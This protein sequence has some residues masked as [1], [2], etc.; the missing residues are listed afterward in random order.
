MLS[1]FKTSVNS[2]P[3]YT[4]NPIKLMSTGQVYAA[5]YFNLYK[6]IIRYTYKNEF[7]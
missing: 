2:V 4:P 7:E 1:I 5:A 3:T 6:Y